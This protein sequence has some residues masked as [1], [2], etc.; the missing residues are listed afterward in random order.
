MP[1]GMAIRPIPAIAV[2]PPRITRHSARIDVSV[3][4]GGECADAPPHR[5]RYAAEGFRVIFTF[6]EVHPGS[7]E[8][9]NKAGKHKA[10]EKLISPLTDRLRKMTHRHREPTEPRKA[11]DSYESE[12]PQEH[13]IRRA[14]QDWQNQ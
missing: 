9:E 6:K 10:Q 7:R 3:A 14:R 2:K 5:P 13:Q 1:V 8:Y 4:H 11:K 12:K